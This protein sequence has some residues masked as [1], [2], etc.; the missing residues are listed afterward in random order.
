[1]IHKSKC[2]FFIFAVQPMVDLAQLMDS[3]IVEFF[4][5]NPKKRCSVEQDTTLQPLLQGV[6]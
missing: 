1:M 5:L 2:L 6:G 3:E 4:G